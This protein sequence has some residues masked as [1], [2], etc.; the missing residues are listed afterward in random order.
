[1]PAR[2]DENSNSD[3]KEKHPANRCQEPEQPGFPPVPKPDHQKSDH[4]RYKR[5]EHKELERH[6]LTDELPYLFRPRDTSA[7]RVEEASETKCGLSSKKLFDFR[8]LKCLIYRRCPS[9]SGWLRH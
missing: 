2:D 4:A 3:R 1:V 6:F 8:L 9:R 7:E 5:Y